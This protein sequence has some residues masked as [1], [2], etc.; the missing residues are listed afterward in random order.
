VAG[1]A[2]RVGQQRREPLHPPEH[3]HVV[4]VDTALD[5]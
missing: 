4:E 2:C 1:E 5:E 3:R